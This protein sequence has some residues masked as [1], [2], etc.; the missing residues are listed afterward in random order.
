MHFNVLE[1]QQQMLT[2]EPCPSSPPDDKPVSG[3]DGLVPECNTSS[4][5]VKEPCN[6][7]SQRVKCLDQHDSEVSSEEPSQE[8]ENHWNWLA[9]TFSQN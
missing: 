6:V 3:D 7:N 8:H 1:L 2:A 9:T 5:G 4:V